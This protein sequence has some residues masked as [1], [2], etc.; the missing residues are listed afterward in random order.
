MQSKAKQSRRS[1]G[2][3]G[4]AQAPLFICYLFPQ[5]GL[6]PP[7]A[8]PWWPCANA[9]SSSDGRACLTSLPASGLL[10]NEEEESEGDPSAPGLDQAMRVLMR[11]L[12]LGARGLCLHLERLPLSSSPLQILPI[13]R[14]PPRSSDSSIRAGVPL[15]LRIWHLTYSWGVSN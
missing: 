9:K 3:F 14:P 11:A 7:L 1:P 15:G 4:E 12:T 8:S 6:A 2:G 5:S 10:A 13:P